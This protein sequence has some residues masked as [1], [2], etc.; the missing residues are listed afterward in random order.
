M[1]PTS[2]GI[3]ISDQLIKS[4][5]IQSQIREDKHRQVNRFYGGTICLDPVGLTVAGKRE[6]K[7]DEIY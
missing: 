6:I 3:S 5:I 2:L 4:S 1:E 7:L